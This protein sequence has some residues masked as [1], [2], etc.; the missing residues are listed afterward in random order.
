MR[1]ANMCERMWR[2]LPYTCTVYKITT[3]V[4]AVV[5]GCE[6][7]DGGAPSDNSGP[8]PKALCDHYIE[9]FPKGHQMNSNT[10][11]IGDFTDSGSGQWKGFTRPAASIP[12]VATI[13]AAAKAFVA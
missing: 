3:P 5:K 6:A 11:A 7:Y 4:V 1:K 12:Q 10:K 8:P 2:H 9:Y 13:E